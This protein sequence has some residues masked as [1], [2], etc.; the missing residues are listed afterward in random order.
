MAK[1]DKMLTELTD[2]KAN[3]ALMEERRK[4]LEQEIIEFLPLETYTVEWEY[5]GKTTKATI[6]YS[7]SVSIDHDALK[8]DLTP[9]Q[10]K[11][12]TTVV[13]DSKALENAVARGDIDVAVVAKHSTEKPKKP[14]IRVTLPKN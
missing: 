8:G 6:V 13:V 5:E 3:I 10:W 11:K 14:Y 9:T 12:I 4:E 7:S 1:L 2:L